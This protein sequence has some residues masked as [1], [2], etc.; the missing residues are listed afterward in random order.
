LTRVMV[1]LSDMPENEGEES[2]RG[3]RRK[4][5]RTRTH[6]LA[7]SNATPKSLVDLE[8][9]VLLLRKAVPPQLLEEEL[10]ASSVV[11]GEANTDTRRARLLLLEVLDQPLLEHRRALVVALVRLGLRVPN[12]AGLASGE[13]GRVRVDLALRLLVSSANELGTETVVVG[14]GVSE[15]SGDLGG[16]VAA[17]ALVG[18]V[19]DGGIG[20]GRGGGGVGGAV[21]LLREE[22]AVAVD[23]GL[24]PGLLSIDEETD[25]L[26]LS[27]SGNLAEAVVELVEELVVLRRK[28]GRL[29]EKDGGGDAASASDLRAVVECGRSPLEDGGV[30][31]ETGELDREESGLD[32]VSRR[33]R[34]EFGG[35]DDSGVNLAHR[36]LVDAVSALTGTEGCLSRVVEHDTDLEGEKKVSCAEIDEKKGKERTNT[37]VRVRLDDGS[38]AGDRLSTSVD[39]VEGV[40]DA[41]Q[42][43]RR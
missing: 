40:V 31:D 25:A 4:R 14:V 7:E 6:E 43:I 39:L 38:A 10:H 35:F 3:K 17:V 18:V 28:F 13:G 32:R 12:D 2:V 19:D 34:G 22:V 37:S 8:S 42:K 27:L 29:G 24:E 33:G 30:V 36:R 11:R 1:R 41:L 9:S 5:E 21:E 20:S 16:R 26:L 23:G 15:L